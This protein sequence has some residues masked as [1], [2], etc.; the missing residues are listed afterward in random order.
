MITT[1]I[2]RS[3]N[4][5]IT[6]HATPV[7]NFTSFHG[8]T[9]DYTIIQLLFATTLFRELP[10]INSVVATN[11]RDQSLFATV[12]YTYM[13]RTCSHRN[14]FSTTRPSLTSGKV[15]ARESWFTIYILIEIS[16]FQMM[17]I[18]R[19]NFKLCL[20]LNCYFW[21]Y[22]RLQ[23]REKQISTSINFCQR[24]FRW[25][26]KGDVLIYRK[27]VGMLQT[28]LSQYAESKLINRSKR[29]IGLFWQ[30]LRKTE[31]VEE[32]SVRPPGRITNLHSKRIIT[33]SL[34]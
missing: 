26:L 17:S 28:W 20:T 31:L 22:P 8:K 21:S 3:K 12:N 27:P 15:F 4:G 13:A 34:S 1:I 11:F 19:Y 23:S 32:N 29:V 33:N 5:T 7:L 14:T 2:S 24:Y 18:K 6:P 9:K 16:F 25:F 10:E 30:K